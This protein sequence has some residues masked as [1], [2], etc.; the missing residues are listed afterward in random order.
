MNTYHA[1]SSLAIVAALGGHII[2]SIAIAYYFG[3][4]MGFAA[5][6]GCL[7]TVIPAGLY[8]MNR[9]SATSRVAV[10]LGLV[11]F[12]GLIVFLTS[13]SEVSHT[14]AFA[15]F[16]ALVFLSDVRALVVGAVA[17]A[18]FIA[19]AYSVIP[20]SIFAE[21]NI[22]KLLALLGG[23]ATSATLAVLLASRYTRY[24]HVFMASTSKLKDMASCVAGASGEI[25]RSGTNLSDGATEQASLASTISDAIDQLTSS[26]DVTQENL[27]KTNE[28]TRS[29][30][31]NAK[32][33]YDRMGDMMKAVGEIEH[34]TDKISDIIKAI[35]E[36][37]F[38]TN[39]LAL[40]A[41][42]EAA[43]AGEA[44]A[45]FAVVADEVRGLAQR[46]ATAAKETENLIRVTVESSK[47]G[48]EICKEVACSI[49]QMRGDI[50]EINR[51]V[52][53]ITHS[54]N[55]QFDGIRQ[56]NGDVKRITDITQNNAAVAEESAAAAQQLKGLADDLNQLVGE[57]DQ[58][59]EGS[60]HPQNTFQ[61]NRRSTSIR[62]R[63]VAPVPANSGNAEYAEFS[64]SNWN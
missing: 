39:I 18:I 40:N 7:L 13:G 26:V 21:P 63:Q 1:K 42:V 27:S 43:R 56:V 10:A 6:A 61:S 48:A 24:S 20:Q 62:Q 3:Q 50:G 52:S 28:L 45:G 37:S 33:G 44:G 2:V 58:N 17:Y 11:G 25:S 64:D 8:F 57:I 55:E 14:H 12:S 54:G 22:G 16:A 49:E 9:T 4:N 60:G 5:I 30:E 59:R 23:I 41:A 47:G 51:L 19:A 32:E 34:N 53:D 38:Q 29:S 36:I 35:D 46:S 15:A 31:S